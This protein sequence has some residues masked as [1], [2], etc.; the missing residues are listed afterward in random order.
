MIKID[1]VVNSFF[2]STTWILSKMKSN[3]VW[4]IDCGDSKPIIDYVN[5]NNLKL[6]GIFFTH[7][8]YDH[9]YGLNEL[10][11]EYPDLIVYTSEYG[12]ECLFSD[13]MNLSIYH[14]NSFIYN[15]SDVRILQ[16]GDRVPIF[17]DLYLNVIET[18]GHCPSCLTYFTEKQIFTGDSYIPG[19][20]VVTKLPKGNK[21]I[22]N[23]S[24][25]KIKKIALNKKIYPGHLL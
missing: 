23:N 18:P 15:G 6:Q 12:K 20:K 11:V 19:L 9:I 2:N 25:N 14:E 7:T 21:E 16:E 24:I 4:L 22:A 17:N 10:L 13:K 8:H 1:Y 5:N 3:Q